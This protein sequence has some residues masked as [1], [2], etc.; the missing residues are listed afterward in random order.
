MVTGDITVERGG[1]AV[2]RGRVNGRVVNQGGTVEIRG[3]VNQLQ[4]DA[5]ET[6]VYGMV[7]RVSG[8]GKVRYVAGAVVGGTRVERDR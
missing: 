1:Y 7:Q 4:A 3:M 5:G 8:S 6:M 2:I